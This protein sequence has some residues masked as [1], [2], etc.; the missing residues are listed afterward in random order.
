M[1]KPAPWKLLL[2]LSALAM[3]FGYIEA[4]VVVYLREISY[5]AGFQSP[6]AAPFWPILRTEIIREAATLVL[7]LSVAW[8][9]TPVLLRRFA[10]LA[11]CFGLWDVVYYI[12]L[13]V[14]LGWPPSLMTWDVL[15]LIP[16]PWTSPVLAPLLVALAL[17]VA[18]LI[19][20][21]L[22][23]DRPT[24][25]RHRD[26]AVEVSAGLIIIASF[27]WNAPVLADGGIPTAFPW[28]LFGLGFLT[29]TGWFAWRLRTAQ[30]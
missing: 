1:E 23:P 12:V 27:L 17:M 7:L 30:P 6:L 26:W 10:V 25:F 18:A 24:P 8:L 11:Y 21:R 9:A 28:W 15:F 13:K 3:A 20:L 2:V 4:A 16:L 19:I 14:T 22:P 29:G 5:P